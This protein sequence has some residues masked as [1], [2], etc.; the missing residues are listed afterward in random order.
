MGPV[1]QRLGE[2]QALAEDRRSPAFQQAK[3][4]AEALQALTWVV[5]SG[6]S[7]GTNPFKGITMMIRP[8]QKDM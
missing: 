8:L 5:Y 7:C 6:P 1:G 3:A 2:A 4:A